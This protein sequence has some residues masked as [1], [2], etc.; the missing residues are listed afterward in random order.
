MTKLELLEHLT[1]NHFENGA[2]FDKEVFASLVELL[3]INEIRKKIFFKYLKITV[4]YTFFIII[5]ASI[6]KN[7]MD[8]NPVIL[9]FL[10]PSFIFL[11][12]SLKPRLQEQMSVFKVYKAYKTL[13]ITEQD[14]KV[15]IKQL[16]QEYR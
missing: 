13:G 14:V 11:F 16:E 7:I 1:P 6:L 9:I 5:L 4:G 10:L 12:M 8:D 15:A 3:K 2:S